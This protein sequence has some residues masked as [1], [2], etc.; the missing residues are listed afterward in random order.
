MLQR[1]A[2]M[3]W[4]SDVSHEHGFGWGAGGWGAGG[5][6]WTMIVVVTMLMVGGATASGWLLGAGEA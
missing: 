2:W 6:A 5:G 3:I 1:V 4:T